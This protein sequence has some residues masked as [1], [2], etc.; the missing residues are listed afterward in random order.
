MAVIRC[1]NCGKPNPEFLELCQYCDTP[2]PAGDAPGG[3]TPA[4]AA[5]PGNNDD[6]LIRLPVWDT[7]AD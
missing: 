2:L 3:G 5:R 7:P 1:P 6:T 4:E